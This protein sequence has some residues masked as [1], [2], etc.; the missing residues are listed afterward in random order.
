MTRAAS[1]VL[2]TVNAPYE[3]TVTAI[4]LAEL[5]SDVEASAAA[6]GPV[7]TFFSEVAPDLQRAFIDD[8]KLPF[9][10][11]QAVAEHLQLSCPFQLAL[12]KPVDR[13]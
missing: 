5:I 11:V 2:G 4:E 10:K 9:S 6:L 3:R 8:M 1:L 13:K 7:F 12:A